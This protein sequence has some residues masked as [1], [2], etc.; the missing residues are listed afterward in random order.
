MSKELACNIHDLIITFLSMNDSKRGFFFWKLYFIL[1]CIINL[2]M[3]K[4]KIM[5]RE[6]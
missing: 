3:G 6:I 5:L 2:M 4:C 1:I